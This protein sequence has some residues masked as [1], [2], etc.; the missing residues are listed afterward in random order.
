M[1]SS[2]RL[3]EPVNYS[4]GSRPYYSINSGMPT[5]PRHQFI[6]PEKAVIERPKVFDISL[7]IQAIGSTVFVSKLDGELLRAYKDISGVEIAA[8]QDRGATVRLVEVENLTKSGN[9]DAKKIYSLSAS[10]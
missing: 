8:G 1:Q 9:N 4:F 3:N 2:L 10:I 6:S 7:S 5:V